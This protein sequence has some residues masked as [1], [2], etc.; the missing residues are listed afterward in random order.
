[1]ATQ[2]Q[3]S[4]AAVLQGLADGESEDDDAENEV[5]GY[6][7]DEEKEAKKENLQLGQ[8]SKSRALTQQD[9]APP[10]SPLCIRIQVHHASQH[11]ERGRVRARVYAVCMC[12]CVCVCVCGEL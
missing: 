10:V 8:P 4:R 9:D 5:V 3:A 12:V 2:A 1:M 6:L 11:G 7:E